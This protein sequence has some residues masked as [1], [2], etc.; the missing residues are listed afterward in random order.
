MQPQQLIEFVASQWPLFLALVLISGAL[1]L[2]F[3]LGEK[4]SVDPIGA[5]ELINRR[6]AVVVDV[7]PVP[8]Y[9]SGHIIGAV[10]LPANGLADHIGTL[11]KHKEKPIVVACRSGS[12][13]MAACQQLRKAGFAEVYN[14][15]GGL[16]AWQNANLPLTRKKG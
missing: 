10:N 6:D 12:Q 13:S 3:I 14:L 9:S 11:K 1:V 16:L 8:D 15:R 4:H 5:T 2:T 7:R